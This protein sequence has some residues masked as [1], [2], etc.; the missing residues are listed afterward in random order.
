[1]STSPVTLAPHILVQILDSSRRLTMGQAKQRGTFEQHKAQA[2]KE[3]RDKDVM[4]RSS[5][6]PGLP[7]LTLLAYMLA[8]KGIRVKL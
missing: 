8:G 3:G 6:R 5:K 4:I 1:M 7:P 2:I